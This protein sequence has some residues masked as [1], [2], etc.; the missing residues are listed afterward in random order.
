MMVFLRT[1]FGGI[2]PRFT[3]N[4]DKE[5]EPLYDWTDMYKVSYS[6]EGEELDYVTIA[7]ILGVSGTSF[8][9]PIKAA[10][11]DLVQ[12]FLFIH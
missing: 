4:Y 8:C 11:I 6:A 2:R 5:D 10:M 9:A 12:Q 1:L 3:G 7:E